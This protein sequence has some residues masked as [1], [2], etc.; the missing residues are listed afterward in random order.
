M[1]NLILGFTC[2]SAM[3]IFLVIT[4]TRICW[5]LIT[6]STVF[7]ESGELILVKYGRNRGRMVVSFGGIFRLCFGQGIV[8]LFHM[9]MLLGRGTDLEVAWI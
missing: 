9:G 8:T 2:S 4:K 1:G 3:L 5:G 7:W 6:L